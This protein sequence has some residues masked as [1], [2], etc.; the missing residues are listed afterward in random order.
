MRVFKYHYEYEDDVPIIILSLLDMLTDKLME[1]ADD[2]PVLADK[3]CNIIKD[4]FE[5]H[6]IECMIEEE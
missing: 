2:N 1:F 6:D 3:I 5:E 4:T